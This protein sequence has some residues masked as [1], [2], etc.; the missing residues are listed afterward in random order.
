MLCINLSEMCIRDRLAAIEESDEIDGLLILLNTV[1]GDIEAGLAIACLLY[2]STE[3]LRGQV[4]RGNILSVRI[5]RRTQMR[6]S[7]MRRA[8]WMLWIRKK[9]QS[10]LQTNFTFGAGNLLHGAMGLSRPVMRQRHL[11]SGCG[12]SFISGNIFR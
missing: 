11:S 8:F 7:A 9:A 2:T 5:N 4:F 3:D 12:Y 1:G 10:L 6:I